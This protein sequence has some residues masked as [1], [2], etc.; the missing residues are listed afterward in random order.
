MRHG[1]EVYPFKL[2]DLGMSFKGKP[3]EIIELF[4]SFANRIGKALERELAESALSKKEFFQEWEKVRR[5]YREARRAKKFLKEH[6]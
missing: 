2:S 5:W 6:Y 1:P 3:K 4:V